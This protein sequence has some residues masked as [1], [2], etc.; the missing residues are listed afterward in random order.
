[1]RR[2]RVL[3][4]AAALA[5][6]A[7]AA[8]A[9]EPLRV[10]ITSVSGQSVYL[11]QGRRAGLTPGLHIRL[12]PASGAP[13]DAVIADV[14][15]S[16]ARVELPEGSPIPQVGS[17]GEVDVPE[18]T[19]P[20]KEEGKPDPK[21]AEPRP[22]PAHAPW[23]RQE[24]PRSADTPLLAPAYA[25]PASERP[26]QFHG[27]VYSQLQYTW[28]R[29]NG[30]D[31]GYLLARLG[32]SLQLTNP[33]GKGGGLFFDGEVDQRDAS[34][35]DSSG[36][37]KTDLILHRASYVQGG[38]QYSSYRAEVG[39][40]TS[41]YMP[42]VG[43][44]DGVEG[45]LLLESGLAIGAGGGVYPQPFPEEHW[46]KDAGFHA[47]V[48][49]DNPKDRTFTGTL[50]VLKTWHEGAPDRDAV[51]GRATWNPTK[52]W[53]VY[54]SFTADIYGSGDPAKSAGIQLTQGWL[55]ARY[56]PDKT[57]GASVSYSRYTWPSLKRDEFLFAPVELIRDGRV[58]RL[59]GS[60][61]REV[62]KDVR[63]TG[64][65]RYYSDHRGDGVGGDAGVDVNRVFD[66][67]ASLR[68]EVFYNQ[69]TTIDGQGFRVELRP[70]S[71]DVQGFV[72]Y[73]LYQ[74]T[75]KGLISGDEHQ[76]RHT[77]RGGINWQVNQWSYS[78]TLDHAFGD[79]EDAYSLG[80]YIEYR[81]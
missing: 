20:P 38:E 43:R 5:C 12:F 4:A 16:S 25:K 64:R 21:G 48:Q 28:D 7:G 81:F 33:F 61:W 66:L 71:G 57:W 75:T 35:V 30:R 46:G 3:A 13:I 14:S 72:G 24:G 59:E 47:F 44:V 80:A 58:D 40:F 2:S 76:V 45:A 36:E 53:W 37:S 11:D 62:A 77:I 56:S 23:T 60:A 39:R 19:A 27:R 10:R 52:E 9:G 73:E 41:Y 17:E 65:A 78:A 49:Y 31:N 8:L 18:A 1:M 68:T 32:G 69:G 67:S 29:G 15:S 50:G 79:N 34:V 54:G 63:L 55:Q 42:E 6:A 70:T 51:I 26:S 74:Y 22:V